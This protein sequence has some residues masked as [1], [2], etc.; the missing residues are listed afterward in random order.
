M[1]TEV[2]SAAFGE[3][4]EIGD[5]NAAVAGALVIVGRGPADRYGGE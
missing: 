3:L 4:I 1:A 5:P 2:M